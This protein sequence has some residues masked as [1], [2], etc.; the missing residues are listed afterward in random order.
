MLGQTTLGWIGKRCKQ[1]TGNYK[2]ILGGMSLILIGDSGQLRPVGDKQL[3]HAKHSSAIGEQG[4][5]T[6]RMFD[7]VVKLTV[8]QR[9]LGISSTQE[10]FR[11]LLL[12]PRKGESTS[13]DW[14]LLL[15][16]Q[17]LHI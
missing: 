9:V 12:R 17:P 2:K 15:T 5:Q 3:F 11:Q 4:N 10:Q 8:N 6:Y 16:R 14:Q 13:E 7:K 1:V